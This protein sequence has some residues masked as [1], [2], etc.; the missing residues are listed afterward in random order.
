MEEPSPPPLAGAEYTSLHRTNTH[1]MTHHTCPP[2]WKGDNTLDA[3]RPR[4]LRR[5]AGSSEGM[6]LDKPKHHPGAR[7]TY[8]VA[9]KNA[10]EWGTTTACWV[11]S[12]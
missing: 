4:T 2:A 5:Q 11:S 8:P 6:V 10:S 9:W 12:L 3:R 7:V 1:R